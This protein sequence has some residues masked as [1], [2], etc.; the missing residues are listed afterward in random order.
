MLLS[1][2]PFRVKKVTLIFILFLRVSQ[3]KEKIIREANEEL[4][5]RAL[6]ELDFIDE[7]EV[8]WKWGFFKRTMHWREKSKVTK[9]NNISI[10]QIFSI[11]L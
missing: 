7:S 6:L 10:E 8:E 1:I 3:R 11:Y 4:V 2:Q 9:A 5:I